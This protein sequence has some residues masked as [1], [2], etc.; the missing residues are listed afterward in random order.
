MNQEYIGLLVFTNL[1][2]FYIGFIFHRYLIIKYTIS[3]RQA[4]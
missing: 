2:S 4:E 3:K 1:T